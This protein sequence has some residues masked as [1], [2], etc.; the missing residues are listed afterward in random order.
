MLLLQRIITMREQPLSPSFIYY[1]CLI[2]LNFIQ[3]IFN[4]LILG[5]RHYLTQ[6]HI[7]IEELKPSSQYPYSAVD[8]AKN[9]SQLWPLQAQTLAVVM[10]VCKWQFKTLTNQAS[11]LLAVM[12][13]VG[14]NFCLLHNPRQYQDFYLMNVKTQSYQVL[15]AWIL[16]SYAFIRQLWPLQ[17]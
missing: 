1:V 4:K 3:Y 15:Y 2:L 13:F 7:Y 8:L 5:Q 16:I 17:A 14:P 6:H 12:T 9:I 10:T 11:C